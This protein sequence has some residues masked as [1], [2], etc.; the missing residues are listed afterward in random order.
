[1]APN[2]K[3]HI[4]SPDKVIKICYSL[5]EL[6]VKSFNFGRGG[7][8]FMKHIKGGVSYNILGASVS[9]HAPRFL[10]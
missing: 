9:H 2:C 4:L 7:V 10:S 5:I 6:C 3:Q 1:M 8:E